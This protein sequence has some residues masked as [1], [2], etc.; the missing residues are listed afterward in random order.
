MRTRSGG[1]RPL[2]EIPV[3]PSRGKNSESLA[4]SVEH[5][6][7]KPSVGGSIPPRLIVPQRPRHPEDE[8][9]LLST[10]EDATVVLAADTGSGTAH[11]ECEPSHRTNYLEVLDGSEHRGYQS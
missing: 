6:P 8:A 10:P 11:P 2:G 7:F 9:R 4:Q 3:G 5:R 1:N